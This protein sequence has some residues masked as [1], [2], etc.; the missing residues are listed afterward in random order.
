MG[1]GYIW[2]W[3]IRGTRMNVFAIYISLASFAVLGSF[4]WEVW[5]ASAWQ[6]IPETMQYIPE[7]N[8]SLLD[9]ACGLIGGIIVGVLHAHV[10]VY[11]QQ[12]SRSD[13]K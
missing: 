3:F 6:I 12:M 13:L 11:S 4:L 7:L 2:L 8:D 5:E 9:I 1:L 10:D